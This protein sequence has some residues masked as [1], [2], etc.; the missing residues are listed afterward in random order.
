[1]A[2]TKQCSGV[3]LAVNIGNDVIQIG[4]VAQQGDRKTWQISTPKAMTAD[5][6]QAVLRGFFQAKECELD[7]LDSDNTARAILASVV[8]SLTDAWVKALHDV[9]GRR[10]LVV[11]PGLKTGLQMNYNDPAEI[12]ADRIADLVAGHTHCE[13]PYVIVDIGT[14][15]NL[16]VV[17]AEGAFCGGIIAP[18]LMLS[19]EALS[20]GAARLHAVDI[21][22]PPSIIGK[23]TITA[24]QS[25][26]FMGEVARIDGLID[27]I[28]DELGYSTDVLV[29][30]S[31]S[32]EILSLMKH[33]GRAEEDLT[34]QGL[35]ILH[36]MNRPS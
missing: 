5:E 3:V 8:P 26:V 1:M 21:K 10:P 4:L 30:G 34:M 36:E 12:G 20:M 27:M 18:G 31:G 15:T 14:T 23:S 17:N 13:F 29:A 19:A 22:A 7:L 9:C 35:F 28:W 24:V 25:G 2:N 33:D 16:S 6:A 11:G 32:A